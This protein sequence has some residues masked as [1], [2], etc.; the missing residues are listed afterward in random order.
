M[1]SSCILNSNPR[2]T[3]AM[4]K[5][6]IALAVFAAALLSSCVQE[7]SFNNKTIGK[8]D[9]VFTLQG[10]PAT[11]S[12]EEMSIVRKG[13]TIEI[14]DDK[15]GNKLFLEETIE[16]LNRVWAPVTRGTPAY[17]EN[18]GV[19]YKN[20]LSV[21]AAP[22]GDANYESMDTEMVGGGWRYNHTYP[23]DPWANGA[24]DFYF[25]MPSD[26]TSNGVSL[27]TDAY[28][29]SGDNLTITFDYVSPIEAKKQQDIIFA[30]RNVTK[31]QY[32]GSL[33]NGVPVLFNH[34]L[35]AV[36]FAIANPE[37]A[38]ITSVEFTG[39]VGE[40]TCTITPAKE[41][42]YRDIT[43]T[44]SSADAVSWTLD[45]EATDATY[46]SG[47]FGDPVSY[48]SGSFANNG[49][50]PSSFAGGGAAQTNNLN[51]ADATQTFWF[52]P[53]E[54]TDDVMLHITYT[55]GEN[56]GEGYIEFG[57]ALT[58]VTW[59]AGQLRTYTIRVDEV[60]V[61][62]EDTVVPIAT[63]NTTL[64]DMDGNI[65]Y[66]EIK[67]ETGTVIRKEEY[68]FTYYGGTKSNIII[69]NTGN[70]DA[71]IRAAL[72]G[73]WLDDEDNP[74]FGFTDYT[75]GKVVLVESWYQ[76]QFKSHNGKH[77]YFTSLPGYRNIKQNTNYSNPLNDWYL[78]SD[79]Y[80]YYK[81]IVPKGTSIPSN[82]PLFTSYTVDKNPAVVIAGEVK[83]VYFVLEIATQA[84]SAKRSDGTD[85]TLSEAW[86][87][88]GV[89]V[90]FPA[91]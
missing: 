26:M 28:G 54:M 80:Y 4:K 91:E 25:R 69:S 55:F 49:K 72:V 41:G 15:N 67:D 61:K 6:H 24:I 89:S 62:I 45:T 88:A 90:T 84:I 77:G 10:A 7:K 36:K 56:E 68:K 66:K 85:A 87:K 35:T 74:V 82:T 42:D 39:L 48:T 22:L 64:T 44:Y 17:T 46:S 52:I 27:G 21:Y 33:P 43:S 9:I 29:K 73:Q 58:G 81:N 37:E 11:R 16:D 40:G 31:D 63:P 78:N 1:K 50:Y 32:T 51:D 23:S 60:N 3:E 86:N 8:N 75:A 19:L 30:A 65:I 38:A 18:V 5:I 79:G 70:T 34:A 57:K 53:Q 14:A 13:V 59:N 47:E 83:D 71:Y 2:K 20:K 12:I 76:D